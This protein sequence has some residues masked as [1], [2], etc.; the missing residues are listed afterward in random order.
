M[1]K[2]SLVLTDDPKLAKVTKNVLQLFPAKHEIYK[3]IFQEVNEKLSKEDV[4][5]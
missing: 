4:F 1:M 3:F 2:D 5:Q